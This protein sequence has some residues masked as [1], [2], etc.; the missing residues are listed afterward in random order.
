MKRVP[1]LPEDKAAAA[2]EGKRLAHA[3]LEAL[4]DLDA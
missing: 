3:A 4:D 2:V 1:C